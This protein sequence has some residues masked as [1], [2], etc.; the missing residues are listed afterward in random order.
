MLP[1]GDVV[2]DDIEKP[3][4]LIAMDCT[5]TAAFPTEVSV[6]I[7]VV[8]WFK[9]TEPNEIVVASTLN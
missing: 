2:T 5:V 6:T 7:W 3:V 1:A 4:P 8:A 9:T